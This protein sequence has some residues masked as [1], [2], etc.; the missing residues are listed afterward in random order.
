MRPFSVDEVER[1]DA[2]GPPAVGLPRLRVALCREPMTVCRLDVSLDGVWIGQL[3]SWH[4]V[5]GA[6]P[7]GAGHVLSARVWLRRLELRDQ[8]NALPGTTPTS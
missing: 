1:Q 2:A 6:D 3:P 7:T 8:I 5:R 4:H